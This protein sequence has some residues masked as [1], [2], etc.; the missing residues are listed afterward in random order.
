MCS[1]PSKIY[2]LCCV[3]VRFVCVINRH[4]RRPSSSCSTTAVRRPRSQIRLPA[5]TAVRFRR[6]IAIQ[7]W[8]AACS[9]PSLLVVVQPPPSAVAAYT[10]TRMC[11]PLCR[12]ATHLERSCCCRS[13][14]SSCSSVAIGKGKRNIRCGTIAGTKAKARLMLRLRPMRIFLQNANVLKLNFKS[15]PTS[16]NKPLA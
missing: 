10:I 1:R 13:S 5:W 4:S 12:V 7:A 6:R 16:N 8:P 11:R 2:V 9:A 14:N 15:F 3:C